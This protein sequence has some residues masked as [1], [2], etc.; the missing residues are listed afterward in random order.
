[1]GRDSIRV[2]KRR[3][4]YLLNVKKWRISCIS[5]ALVQ[6]CLDGLKR[7]L[8]RFKD[9]FKLSLIIFLNCRRIAR[10]AAREMPEKCGDNARESAREMATEMPGKC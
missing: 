1:M 6:S 2:V 5:C 9:Q 7:V 4:A 3:V 10:E 8:K